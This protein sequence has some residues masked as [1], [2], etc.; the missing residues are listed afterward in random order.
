SRTPR[1]PD[2]TAPRG[3]SEQFRGRPWQAAFLPAGRARPS[4]LT[5]EQCGEQ[6]HRAALVEWVVLVP[7]LG[8]L[9][10]RRAS[11][12][13]FTVCN[14]LACRSQPLARRGVPVFGESGS[15]GVAVVHEDREP[16]GVGVP[17]G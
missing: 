8:R 1:R 5:A 12:R 13:T 6:R 10:A 14:R 15:A 16:A 11:V 17:G 2:R 4:G 9:Y 7:T 3:R